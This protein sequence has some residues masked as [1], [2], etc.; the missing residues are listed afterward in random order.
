MPDKN[1]P[2]LSLDAPFYFP[3][4]NGLYEVKPG[5]FKFPHNF[6]YPEQDGKV[7][8]LDREFSRYRQEK[9]ASRQENLSKYYCHHQFEEDD[10][11]L[12][13]RFIIN[14]LISEYPNVFQC[15]QDRHE[16]RLECKLTQETLYFDKNYQ[17][18][19]VISDTTIS[20]DYIDGFDALACQIQEDL[21]VIKL[22]ST[23]VDQ[24]IALH[25]CLPNHW[26][27]EHKIGKAFIAVHEPI[28]HMKKM[29]QTV[30]QLMDAII[31]KGPFVRF[32]WGLATDNRLNH[33]PV[34]AVNVDPEQ[35]QG[36]AFNPTIPELYLRVERQTLHGFS[37]HR[38]ALFTIRT[39][40]YDVKWI[41]HHLPEQIPLL[42]NAIKSMSSD[43]LDYKGLHDHAPA[44]L[45]WLKIK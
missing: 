39:Y 20:Q 7:F 12:I 44:I 21:S 10:S 16:F 28:P 37:Q 31:N 22:N 29:N 42:S 36:R 6:G 17:L 41:K 24:S 27:A 15:R 14:Q 30:S 9:M 23:G 33:H 45:S 1:Q 4:E 43:S 3:L 11:S 25:L 18:I 5:L 19:K 8:Q 26:A 38:L 35:W 34:P 2:E 13:N 40:I 32:A